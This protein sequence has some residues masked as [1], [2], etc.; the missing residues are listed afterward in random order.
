MK[1]WREAERLA[2]RTIEDRGYIV[3]DANVLF[4]ENCPNV[5]LV[6]FGC[7]AAVYVQVKSTSK[8]AQRGCIIVDGSTWSR[9]QLFEAAPIYN[10][11]AG[12]KAHHVLFIDAQG[13][14]DPAFYLAP[15]DEIEQMVRERGLAY[16]QKPKRDG[17]TRSL[18]FRKELP[19]EAMAPWRDRWDLLGLPIARG[20]DAVDHRKENRLLRS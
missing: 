2:R 3:H 4:R 8:P 20:A 14:G 9:Q 13:P 7:D 18:G 17:A 15:P 6:V 10:K 19:S 5:D 1:F 12:F 11:H 16:A